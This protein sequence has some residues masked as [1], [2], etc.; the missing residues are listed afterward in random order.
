MK[1]AVSPV[2]GLGSQPSTL[3]FSHVRCDKV[4][5]QSSKRFNGELNTGINFPPFLPQ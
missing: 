3:A 4:R 1:K 2:F 5:E